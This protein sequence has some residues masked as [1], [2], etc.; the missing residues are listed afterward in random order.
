M[1]PEE[2][3]DDIVPPMAGDAD[4]AAA[5]AAEFRPP[6]PAGAIEPFAGQLPAPEEPIRIVVE[7][8]AHGW[9]VDHYLCRLFPNFSRAS[10]Q[11]TI[12]E[13]VRLN[14][15]PT[16]PGRRL[17]VND[18]LYV[19]L[20]EEREADLVPENIPLDIIFEDEFLV[21]I[22]KPWGLIVHPGRGNPTGTLAAALQFHFDALSS[23]AGRFRPGIVHRLDKDTSGVLVVAKSNQIHDRLTK[24]FE[25]RTVEKE[26]RAIVHGSPHYDSEWIETHMRVHPKVRE[27]MQVCREDAGSR[28][29]STF[30]EV[31]ERFRDYAY[32]RLF[33]KTGRTHQLRVHMQHIG[34]PIVAD[35]AYGG[36]GVLM[37]SEA[38][39]TVAAGS[40]ADRPLIHRQALHARRLTI[41]HPQTGR[42]VTF[43]AP[44]PADM[45]GTL[46][47]LRGSLGAA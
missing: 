14:N 36:R 32:V 4:T 7:A 46:A 18:I 34:H 39:R 42:P 20:P 37:S 25:A 8:R 9:R 11:R 17:R 12:E 6:E 5:A 29:A 47:V 30:Y 21:A 43:E 28:H 2:L 16:K 44:L 40:A 19:R 38:D 22:N 26:Y 1:S 45:A 27:R 13:Q 35:K 24:Q 10:W 3:D 41:A 31:A 15:N 23:A 33:P